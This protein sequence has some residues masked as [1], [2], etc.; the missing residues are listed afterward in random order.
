MV[1]NRRQYPRQQSKDGWPRAR[2]VPMPLT[3][4]TIW[5]MIFDMARSPNGGKIFVNNYDLIDRLSLKAARKIVH[6][7]VLMITRN[8]GEAFRKLHTEAISHGQNVSDMPHLQT[9]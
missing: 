2:I 6:N 9:P 8:D 7:E 4:Y 5:Y 1:M 3:E